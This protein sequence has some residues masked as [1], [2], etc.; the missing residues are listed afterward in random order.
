M[1]SETP[2]ATADSVYRLV[3]NRA[4]QHL[5]DKLVPFLN[6]GRTGESDQILDALLYTSR[7]AEDLIDRAQDAFDANDIV[8]QDRYARLLIE[9]FPTFPE[10]YCFQIAVLQ[11][12]GN[13][14]EA[15]RLILTAAELFPRFVPILKLKAHLHFSKGDASA[16]AD[17]F[18]KVIA[19][20][21]DDLD[22]RL[23]LGYLS[24]DAQQFEAAAE[25]FRSVAADNVEAL[26]GIAYYGRATQNLEVETQ[27][28]S[29]VRELDPN[30]PELQEFR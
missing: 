5:M 12:R 20:V 9:R 28:V 26:I 14:L 2:R 13:L 18:Q 17:V 22:A 11:K 30:H 6:Q 7:A 8:S 29:R 1:R 15:E 19:E 23:C 21:P 16:A 4:A 24:L 10:G 27:A 25:H 3:E